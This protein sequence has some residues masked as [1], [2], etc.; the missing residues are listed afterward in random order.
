LALGFSPDVDGATGAAGRIA[1]TGAA[2]GFD[3]GRA[4]GIGAGAA[5]CGFGVTVLSAAAG[6]PSA[7]AAAG[8]GSEAGK[9]TA[10]TD[11]AASKPR[12]SSAFCGRAEGCTLKAASIAARNPA[13]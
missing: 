3:S 8:F 12:I 4:S 9:T 6:P 7:T 13:E 1:A 10:L 2:G 11:S 5:G